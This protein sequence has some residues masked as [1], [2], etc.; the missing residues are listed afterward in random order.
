M[1]LPLSDLHLRDILIDVAGVTSWYEGSSSRRASIFRVGRVW[2]AA[3]VKFANPH[4]LS[5]RHY[6]L[7]VTVEPV[8]GGPVHDPQGASFG[9]ISGGDQGNRS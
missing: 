1:A 4:K 2:L 8:G 9:L 5:M 3:T 7:A 6:G